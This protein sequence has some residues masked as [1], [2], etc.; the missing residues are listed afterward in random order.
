MEI[1]AEQ[2]F[3]VVLPMPSDLTKPFPEILERPGKT[4][5]AD[6]AVPLVKSVPMTA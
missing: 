5:G 3:T 2:N 1:G 6:H 4:D